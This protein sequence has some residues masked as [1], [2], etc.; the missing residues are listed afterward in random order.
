MQKYGF[1]NGCINCRT[2]FSGFKVVFRLHFGQSTLKTS[3]VTVG[4]SDACKIWNRLKPY[5]MF[6]FKTCGAYCVEISDSHTVGWEVGLGVSVIQ[7]NQ[8]FYKFLIFLYFIFVH[9]R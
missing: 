4:Y 9:S 2:A 1:G 6:G 5:F 8:Y 7:M 3:Y